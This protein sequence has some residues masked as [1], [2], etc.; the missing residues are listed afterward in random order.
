[1]A[2][3][4]GLEDARAAALTHAPQA[5]VT[6]LYITLKTARCD[7]KPCTVNHLRHAQNAPCT[8]CDRQTAMALE[9]DGDV[10]PCE[11]LCRHS[12]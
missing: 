10:E 8:V 11:Q 9:L 2:R 7:A 5:R 4:M 3:D 6:L 12:S 1:M